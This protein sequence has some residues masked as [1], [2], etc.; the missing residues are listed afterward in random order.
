MTAVAAGADFMAE[1]RPLKV[2][3]CLPSGAQPVEASSEKLSSLLGKIEDFE[4]AANFIKQ[5]P[6]RGPYLVN[7]QTK[8]AFYKYYKQATLGPCEHHGGPKPCL[9]QPEKLKR[10]EAW[11]SLGDMPPERAE[12]CYLDLLRA[13]GSAVAQSQGL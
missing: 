6:C 7:D 11:E 9:T 4:Q 1:A 5:L 13:V 3:R 8:L 2:R 10:W 12:V